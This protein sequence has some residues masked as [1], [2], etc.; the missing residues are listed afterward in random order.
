M[1]D[2][3]INIR[4]IPRHDTEA[5]WKTAD[6]VLL[7]GELGFSSDKN[8]LF[9]V[10]DG[11][12]KWSALPYCSAL[13]D[14]A[15]QQINTTYIKGLSINGK[16]ITYT[17]G[18]GTTGTITTQDTNTWRGIQNNLTSTATDQSLSAAQGKILNEKFASYVPTTRT[19]NGKAL[20]SNISLTA[21]D[22]GASA[23][24]HSHRRISMVGSDT[25]NTNGWYKVADKTFSGY[26]DS[27]ILFAIT[28]TYANHF[29]GIL[30]LQM[31]S[32]NTKISC[33]RLS[34]LARSG[35]AVGD[36]IVNISGMKMTLYVN[37]KISQYGRIQFEIIS[38]SSINNASSGLVLYNTSTKESTTPTATVTA[39]DGSTVNYAN[40]AGAV[41]WGNVSGKPSTFTPATH[42]HN[43]AGSSSAGGSAT[44]AVKLDT[45]TAGSA[46]QPVYFRG[47]KPVATTYTLAKSVP[48]DAKFTDTNTWTALK[49]A[50]TS[51]AGTAGY[52]PAPSAGAANRYLRSDGTWAVPPDNNTTYSNFV[53]SGSGAKAGLVPAPSTTAGT[54]K[55]LR[56]DG[57]WQ[58]P[59]NTTYSAATTSVNGLMSSADKLKLDGIASG[60]NKYT[61]PSY[62]AKTSGFYKVTIDSTGH[63]NA[64]T[65]VTK[66]D[67]TNLGIP[68]S[69]TW[70]GIQNN[71]TSSDTD[72][73]LSANQG[74]L[75]KSYIDNHTS[76]LTDLQ[77][78]VLQVAGD[79][80]TEATEVDMD[81]IFE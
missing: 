27:N 74:R 7:N 73:S 8:N 46:T 24:G 12:S 36:V 55:Y 13:K 43:Y 65:A 62:T 81:A 17:K 22:V 60:A 57:T 15:G 79:V 4:L 30:S 53:K 63:V 35:F 64:T 71:L 48:A 69:N 34:W 67:I 31:R 29:V 37:Q 10:G 45:A 68:A 20:S 40:S 32:D 28:S 2:K 39:T 70:R 3:T 50:T 47:G 1:A 16:T 78:T 18:D 54:T 25:A 23:S 75:L 59:P 26:G 80:W 61:H 72:Q 38:E 52:A 51:T 76:I 44:S 21:S 9:K 6:P 11:K 41:A 19:V 58:T 42:T 14:S 66:T 33:G 5:N 77:N 56:E 49:G